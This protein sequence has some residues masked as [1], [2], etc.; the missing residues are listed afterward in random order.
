MTTHR[1]INK[2]ESGFT[3]IE[4][5][6][7]TFITTVGILGVLSMFISSMKANQLGRN[8]TVGNRL[9]QNMIE[10][11]KTSTFNDTANLLCSTA[12]MVPGSCSVP[13]TVGSV[14]TV[15]GKFQQKTALDLNILI[16][17]IT[18]EKVSNQ[19]NAGV[20]MKGVDRITVT[21]HW[22]DS[23]GHHYTKVITFVEG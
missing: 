20:P 10:Q 16:Y 11:V 1:D 23:Y 3:L 5:L 12:G 4:V 21:V 14:T 22:K 19:L 13:S 17:D 6:I 2:T 9:A 7:A 18:L 15:T 8:T